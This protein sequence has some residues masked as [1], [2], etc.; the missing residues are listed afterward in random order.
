ME[1]TSAVEHAGGPIDLTCETAYS[2]EDHDN[3]TVQGG[4]MLI[5]KIGSVN[6]GGAT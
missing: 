6:G 4:T 5:T 1:I 2:P 3:Y